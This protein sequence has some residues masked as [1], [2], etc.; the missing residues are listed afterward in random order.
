VKNQKQGLILGLSQGL[1][2]R[3]QDSRPN[4]NKRGAPRKPNPMLKANM[5][6]SE[7]V[8]SLVSGSCRGLTA[9]HQRRI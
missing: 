6:V 8:L 1:C 9:P 2:R 4:Q 7:Q 3:A 5:A